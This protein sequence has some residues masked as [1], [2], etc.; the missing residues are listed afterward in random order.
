MVSV[1]DSTVQKDSFP[2]C[3]LCPEGRWPPVTVLRIKQSN[4]AN[5][6]NNNCATA[7]SA[8]LTPM[9]ALAQ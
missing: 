6:R 5:Y 2:S 4:P 9:E 8:G 7:T 3:L 1:D